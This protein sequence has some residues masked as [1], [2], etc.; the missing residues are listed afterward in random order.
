[1]DCHAEANSTYGSHQLLDACQRFA[2]KGQKA[3]TRCRQPQ[4]RERSITG[5]IGHTHWEPSVRRTRW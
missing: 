2:V 5:S 4:L 1:M 3:G